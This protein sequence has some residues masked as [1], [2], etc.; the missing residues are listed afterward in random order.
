MVLEFTVSTTK[1]KVC[2]LSTPETV[3]AAVEGGADFIGLVFFAKSPRNVTIQ[4]AADLA[5]IAKAAGVGVVAVTVDAP[6][7]LLDEI[8]AIVAPDLFQ[9]HGAETPTRADEV[10]K[11][12][13]TPVMR[14][15]RVGEA[16]DLDGLE[17]FEAAADYLMFDA[18]APPGAVLP[19]GNGASFD[20]SILSGR[21][22]AK[23]WFLAGGLN[24]ANVGEAI[25]QSG[26]DLVDVSSGVESAPGVKDAILIEAFLKAV[27]RAEVAGV[28][29]RLKS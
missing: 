29:R 6:S 1:V 14:A 17:A 16:S 4:L 13:S 11:L 3:R 2:G 24:A 8:A 5:S 15:L 28:E 7:I 23:P 9:L 27:R 26:A 21:T 10:R 12:T 19:G 20:W 18:K 25:A 22:F